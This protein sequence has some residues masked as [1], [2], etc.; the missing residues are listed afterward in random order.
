MQMVCLGHELYE[1]QAL[2]YYLGA[3]ISHGLQVV[4]HQI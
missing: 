1:L 3:S 4:W 2:F